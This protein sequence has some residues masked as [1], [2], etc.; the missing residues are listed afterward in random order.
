MKMLKSLRPYADVKRLVQYGTDLRLEG[1][2]SDTLA[3]NRFGQQDNE[4]IQAVG[5][6][7]ESALEEAAQVF[8]GYLEY[9]APDGECKTKLEDVLNYLHTFFYEPRDE[10]YVDKVISFFTLLRNNH[11]NIGKLIVAFNQLNF[12]FTTYLLSKKGLTP[13]KCLNLMESLQRATN[14]EQ[15]VLIEVFTE[16]IMEEAAKGISQLL[17]KNAEIMYVK[18]LLFKLKEQDTEIQS[19]TAAGEQLTASIDEVAHNTVSVSESSAESVRKS[20][21]GKVVIEQAL[22]EIVHTKE[23]FQNIVQKEEELQISVKKI[24]D[25]A[26]IIKNIADQTNLLA[27]NAS[28]E[29]ARAGEAG[30]GF[31]VVANEVRKLAETTVTHVQSVSENIATLQAIAQ[32]ISQLTMTT[33]QV[34]DNGVQEAQ[35]A[36]PLL[37]EILERMNEI[38]EATTNTAA[39]AQEQA[40][41]INDV[42][43]RMVFITELAQDVQALGQQTGEAIYELSKLTEEYRLALFSNNIHL[44]TRALLELA[45]TDHILW[46]WRIYNMLI[47]L[48]QIDPALV[49]SHKDCRLGKWYF[50]PATVKRV[51]DSLAYREIDKPHQQVHEFAKLAAESYNKGNIKEAEAYMHRLEEASNQ[52]LFYID[53]LI[54]ELGI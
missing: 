36:V 38:N 20:E 22:A 1:R 33:S 16:K 29:A 31:A 24:E 44:S 5:K 10:K 9:I 6:I 7:M 39:I 19:V 30:R 46:K 12:F 41:A 43:N 35:K 3:Y 14:I 48:E 54:D 4:N 32:E 15:Q 49:S 42:A 52:V 23:Q 51:K 18:D 26:G 25:V 11:L 34:I 17:S 2:F 8:L 50:N 27:L 47:G 21:E 45:K 40:S 28:I 53:Q 13:R 37:N